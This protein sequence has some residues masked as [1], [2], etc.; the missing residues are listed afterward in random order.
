MNTPFSRFSKKEIFALIVTGIIT[1]LMGSVLFFAQADTESFLSDLEKT[2]PIPENI[3]A[4]IPQSQSTG[5]SLVSITGS[6]SAATGSTVAIKKPDSLPV[7]IPT[8][9]SALNVP[10]IPNSVWS[11]ISQNSGVNHLNETEA[12]SLESAPQCDLPAVKF[13]QI[14]EQATKSILRWQEVPGTNTY[15]VFKR[16]HSRDF[17]FI[18]RV[19]QPTYTVYLAK[20]RIVYED[21][22]ISAVCPE[23]KVASM[24]SSKSTSVR[25][26]VSEILLAIFSM[27]GGLCIVFRK[28]LINL[29]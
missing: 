27:I 23:I 9:T 28:K 10:K 11:T 1:F 4:P 2:F 22:K 24:N 14:E 12:T 20:G 5:T 18:E 25:T 26:G 16:T 17:V 7:T 3:P 13:L 8:S 15:D 29:L 6:S 21:F 19:T